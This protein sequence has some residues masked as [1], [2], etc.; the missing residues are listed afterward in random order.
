MR[1]CIFGR[2]WSLCFSF[3][4]L[5]LIIQKCDAQGWDCMLAQEERANEN[6][7]TIRILDP[8][9]L[10]MGAPVASQGPALLTV[11]P[12]W[13]LRPKYQMAI[14]CSGPGLVFSTWVFTGWW[15]PVQP[16]P[17]GSA[18][19]LLQVLWMKTSACGL[20]W[21]P[22]LDNCCWMSC[23]TQT[24]L[25]CITTPILTPSSQWLMDAGAQTLV[26]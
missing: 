21:V 1:V 3:F 25:R 4:S 26:P 12:H 20:L 14:K 18:S 23:P 5:F 13:C 24:V 15:C 16:S 19:C 9:P 8:E 10:C 2:I 6:A 7:W 11:I 22:S 17:P